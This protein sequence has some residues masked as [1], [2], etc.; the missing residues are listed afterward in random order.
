MLRLRPL[1]RAL[2]ERERERRILCMRF[3]CYTR[4]FC[5]MTQD[6]IGLQ[7]SLWQMQVS[8]LIVRTCARPHDRVMAEACG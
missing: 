1:L 6:R 4:F 5:A 8:R 2:P 7:L 3:F